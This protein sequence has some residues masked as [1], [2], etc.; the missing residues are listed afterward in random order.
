MTIKVQDEKFGLAVI[1]ASTNCV[2]RRNLWNK[3]TNTLAIIDIHWFFIRD[4]NTI[5]G[6]QE[7]IDSHQPTRTPM[8]DFS[9]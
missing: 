1:Y 9:T 5:L 4:F 7:Y 6:A 8:E 3:L 2:T